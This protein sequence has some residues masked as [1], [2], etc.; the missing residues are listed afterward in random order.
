MSS[1][2]FSMKSGDLTYKKECISTLT[3]LSTTIPFNIL[4]LS[5]IHIDRNEFFSR[6]F[7]E[8]DF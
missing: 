7:Q 5:G 8:R 1:L 6:R 4:N 3:F 2:S